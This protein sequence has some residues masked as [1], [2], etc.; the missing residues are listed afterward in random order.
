MSQ[1]LRVLALIKGLGPGGA[2]K[3]LVS[4]ARVRDREAFDFEVAYLLPGKTQFAPDLEELGVR[5]RCFGVRNAQDPRWLLQLRR[6]LMSERYDIVHLHSP[7]VAGMARLVI[8]TMPRSRRP[9]VI[10]TEHNVWS[11]HT[12]ATRALNATT[13]PLGDAWLAVSDE[14][15]ASIPE[16]LRRRVEVVVH[17]I[18]LADLATTADARASVRT[19]LAIGPDEV[20]VATVAN[21]RA[22]KAYPD[23][24]EAARL[25]ADRKVPVRFVIIGQGPLEAEVRSLRASL[26]LEHSVDLLGFRPDV[27]RILAGCDVFALASHYEGYPIAVMEA[28]AVGLPIVATAVGGVPDGV[29]DGVE[30][31]LVP[32]KRPDML[33][34]AIEALVRDPQRRAAMGAAAA[35]RGRGYDIEHAVH[36]V[37]AISRDLGQRNAT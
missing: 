36:R 4:G 18:V 8:R 20:V 26:G 9:K 10:S 1:R 25:L 3:L 37:E 27:L 13:F 22:Q 7:Y 29:R 17:G 12:R 21:F 23:L 31:L 16:R 24:L 33:A 32:P 34:A 6:L 2:E 5:T 19:E 30:G 14:V 15:R 28:L 11:S 35:E